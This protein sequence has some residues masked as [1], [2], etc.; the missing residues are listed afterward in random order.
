MNLFLIGLAGLRPLVS[1]FENVIGIHY[2]TLVEKEK[3]SCNL[4]L[5]LPCESSDLFLR[6]QLSWLFANNRLLFQFIS[7]P[8][9]TSTKAYQSQ[10]IHIKSMQHKHASDT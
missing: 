1:P 10:T 6:Q 5:D 2:N 9:I 8:I 3:G 7:T 4:D